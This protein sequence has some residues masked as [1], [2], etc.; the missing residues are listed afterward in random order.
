MKNQ[1]SFLNKFLQYSEEREAEIE[2]KGGGG[3]K[4]GGEKEGGGG[5]RGEEEEKAGK[6]KA[7]ENDYLYR[8]LFTSRPDIQAHK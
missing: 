5:G 2:G 6:K 1:I 8:T 4:G 3:E 7:R